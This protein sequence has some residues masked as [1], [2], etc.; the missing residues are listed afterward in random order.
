VTIFGLSLENM[1]EE[2]GQ[3]PGK[4]ERKIQAAREA[5]L[6]RVMGEKKD[7]GTGFAD[8]ALMFK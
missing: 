5:L 1:L 4:E 7:E 3:K 8:P 6:D 2:A